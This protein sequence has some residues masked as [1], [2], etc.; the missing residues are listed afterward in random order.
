MK[1][2]KL[3]KFIEHLEDLKKSVGDIDIYPIYHDNFE[4]NAKLIKRVN[5]MTGKECK[6]DF[7]GYFNTVINDDTPDNITFLVFGD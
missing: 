1:K 2:M 3:S 4:D 7:K 5:V 6:R